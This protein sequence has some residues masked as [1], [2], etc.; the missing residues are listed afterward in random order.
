MA[1]RRRILIADDHPMMRAA[2]GQAL[3]QALPDCRQVEA[4][5]LGVK[6]SVNFVVY[7]MTH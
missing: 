3:I 4:A 6:M 7:A 2:L 1:D 5:S